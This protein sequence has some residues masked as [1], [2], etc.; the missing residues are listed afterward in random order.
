[1]TKTVLIAILLTGV[2]VGTAAASPRKKSRGQ[3]KKTS[4]SRKSTSSKGPS[5]NERSR[6]NSYAR[7]VQ[8]KP[9]ASIGRGQVTGVNINIRS[10][11]STDSSVVTK[12]SGGEVAILARQGEWLKLRFAHGTQGWVRSDFVKVYGGSNSNAPKVSLAAVAA[13]VVAEKP[14][15]KLVVDPT[16]RKVTLVNKSAKVHRGPSVTNSVI[17]RVNGGD[18]EVTDMWQNWVQLKFKYGTKGWVQRQ[19]VIFPKN[20]SFVGN[21]AAEKALS[22]HDEKVVTKRPDSPAESIATVVENTSKDSGMIVITNVEP[23]VVKP[24]GEPATQV[25]ATKQY[26]TLAASAVNVRRGPSLTNSIVKKV[27]SGKG[28]ILE[29]HA[30]WYKLKFSPTVVGWVREDFLT[31][32]GGVS[33]PSAPERP[34]EIVASASSDKV[35]K[36]L[37]SANSFRGTRYS[38][39]AASR[40]A[41]DCSGF[42]LQVFRANGISLPRT[43]R[44]QITVGKP[45]SRGDLEAGD[46][47]FFRT[48]GYVSHVGIYIGNNRFIHASSGSRK[49]VESSLGQSYYANR[50]CGARRVIKGSKK[51]DLPKGTPEPSL[52]PMNIEPPKVENLPGTVEIIPPTPDPTLV[53]DFSF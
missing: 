3:A 27:S 26:A 12:V 36:V 30:N 16:S 18:A 25:V 37:R 50:Y 41:T 48:K 8:Y 13:K 34:R 51:I 20:F 42:T 44:E 4:I 10:K 35:E 22:K 46:L 32:S 29:K 40:S 11:P 23:E 6:A 33:A 15:E 2:L 53:K 47:V 9:A 45:V 19:F 5:R 24:V 38:Y 7:S 17:T 39:G 52:P 1:M 14:S 28:E 49:V 43:A 21:F 31:V